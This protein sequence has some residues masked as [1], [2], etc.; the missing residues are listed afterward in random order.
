MKVY[1][2]VTER[3]GEKIKEQGKIS[4]EIVREEFR[5]AAETMQEV[6]DAIEWMRN[7]P[8]RAILAFLEEAPA[9][10]VLVPNAKVTGRPIK[11]IETENWTMNTRNFVKKSL[12]GLSLLT[13]M[14]AINC[15]AEEA[16]RTY[17]NYGHFYV[18]HFSYTT[19]SYSVP[20]TM[21][22]QPHYSA[23]ISVYEVLNGGK[24]LLS[25]FEGKYT[26]KGCFEDDPK[27][28]VKYAIEK[29]KGG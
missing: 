15:Y 1:R 10:T 9:I 16:E 28:L 26:E 4:T 6:W 2:V 20:A 14:L 27:S 24:K 23:T 13:V 17:E 21:S 18:V 25:E 8:E 12:I 3:D 7:D 5:Y 11:T 19:R 22:G 29:A